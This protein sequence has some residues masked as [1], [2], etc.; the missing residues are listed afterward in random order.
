MPMKGV[1]E[2][3]AQAVLKMG[4]AAKRQIISLIEKTELDVSTM[5]RL[6][7]MVEKYWADKE[8]G[9]L[10]TSGTESGTARSLE[11]IIPYFQLVISVWWRRKRTWHLTVSIPKLRSATRLRQLYRM[12]ISGRNRAFRGVYRGWL[13]IAAKTGHKARAAHAVIKMP[14]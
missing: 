8:H 9:S 7:D 12:T 2:K 6:I 13:L 1:D 3:D 4:D 5:R 14:L 11:I 10:I